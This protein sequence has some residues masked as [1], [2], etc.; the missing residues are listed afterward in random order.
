MIHAKL[1]ERSPSA[2]A[3]TIRRPTTSDGHSLNQLIER[4]PPLDANSIYC[5][6]LQ[7]THFAD[8]A[9]V[10]ELK[11][12]LVGSVTGY[13]LPHRDDT[14]F[15]WQVAVDQRARGRGLA[16]RLIRHILRRPNLEQVRRIETTIEP[17]NG[18]SWG[19][20]TS[21]ARELDAPARREVLFASERHFE[22]QHND[23]VLLRIGPFGDGF[24]A[25]YPGFAQE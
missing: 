22:G 6:L 25:N 8:T 18:A 2:D 21:L 9:A 20:F 12:H 19:L 1:S 16:K 23:E 11:G 24:R 7:V 10:A 14:L 4:C 17:D 5:N 15:I 3:L 13:R